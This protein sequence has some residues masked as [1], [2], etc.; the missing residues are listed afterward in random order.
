MRQRISVDVIVLNLACRSL[1]SHTRACEVAAKLFLQMRLPG[2]CF[3]RG[4]ATCTPPSFALPA[5]KV[6]PPPVTGVL[7]L[8]VSQERICFV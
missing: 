8:R 5:R 2:E 6:T 3:L 7:Q 4:T 1:R